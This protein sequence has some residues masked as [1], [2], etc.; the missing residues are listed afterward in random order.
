[1]IQVRAP[2]LQRQK[3]GSLYIE[4]T[5][6]GTWESFPLFALALAS[7]IGAEVVETVEAPDMRLWKIDYSGHKLRLVYD[8][9]PNGVT[10]E[11][12]TEGQ[13]AVIESLFGIFNS[14]AVT[15]GV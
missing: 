5:E 12:T 13:D 8:D 14:Q 2:R 6:D 10:L 3:S 15:N 11:P 7:Q 1:M 9:F 4:L